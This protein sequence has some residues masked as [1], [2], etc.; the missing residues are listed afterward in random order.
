MFVT[1]EVPSGM[2]LEVCDCQEINGFPLGP[3]HPA[4][5]SQPPSLRR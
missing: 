4:I 3:A 5:V 1:H 2:G